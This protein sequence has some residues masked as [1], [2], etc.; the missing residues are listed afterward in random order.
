MKYNERN[1]CPPVTV[2]NLFFWIHIMV[3]ALPGQAPGTS[4]DGTVSNMFPAVSEGSLRFHVDAVQYADRD[5][6]TRVELIYAFDI[7]QLHVGDSFQD[8]VTMQIDLMNKNN[9][10]TDGIVEIHPVSTMTDSDFRSDGI[11][12]NEVSFMALPGDYH[13][14][15][16]MRL[17]RNDAAGTVEGPFH[18]RRFGAGFSVSDIALISHVQKAGEEGT[19]V[20]HGLT[21]LPSITRRFK[22][23]NRPNRFFAYYEINRLTP[24]ADS[25]AYYD[26]SYLV[27]DLKG[28]TRLKGGERNLATTS[29]NTSRID[30]IPTDQLGPGT[31]F[32]IFEVTDS[33]SGSKDVIRRKFDMVSPVSVPELNLP[34]AASDQQKYFDQIRYIATADEIRIYQELDN[35]GKEAF[36]LDF[37]QRRDPDPGTPENEFMIEHFRRLEIAQ[38]RFTGGIH[39]DMGRIFIQY[40]PPLDIEREYPGPGQ[41]MDVEIWIYGINGHSEFVF[42][43][44][45][46]DGHFRLMHSTHPEEYQNPYWRNEVQ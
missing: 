27:T 33:V 5:L 3:S 7:R 31:Y 15:C 17:G 13:L 41:S 12:I 14:Q 18:I 2:L 25:V 45:S 24:D 28:I 11:L 6:L 30:I 22:T 19:F 43:D 10:K 39:S 20:R 8:T 35:S 42:V 38:S 9:Q 16:V 26:V 1:M 40:G 37:W 4:A 23:D 44:R 46:R 32:L 36:L 29:V 34:M 21:M